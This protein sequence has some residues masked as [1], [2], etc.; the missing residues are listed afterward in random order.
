MRKLIWLVGVAVVTSACSGESLMTAPSA[1]GGSSSERVSAQGAPPNST[2]GPGAGTGT[3][4]TVGVPNSCPTDRPVVSVNANNDKHDFSVTRV[5]GQTRSYEW[6]VERDT[7][8][9]YRF[10]LRLF[11]DA[12]DGRGGLYAQ[13]PTLA[14]G[15]YRVRARALRTGCGA[16]DQGTWSDWQPFSVAGPPQPPSAPVV[17]PPPPPPNGCEAIPT[18]GRGGTDPQPC[19]GQ[20]DE[21]GRGHGTP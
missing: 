18:T 17:V 5:A 11:S 6:E 3:L 1:V 14:A 2:I 19:H 10:L 21:D 8:N 16:N 9:V 7:A 12:N 20:D 15:R 4:P 13:P